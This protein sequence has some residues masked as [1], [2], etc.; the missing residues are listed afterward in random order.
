M[1]L[2]LQLMTAC[3]RSVPML[4]VFDKCPCIRR[5][6]EQQL[7]RVHADEDAPFGVS[8][9]PGIVGNLDKKVG[10]LR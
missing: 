7:G 6:N 2:L 1:K 9:R 10:C 3:S 4:T 8:N 5:N